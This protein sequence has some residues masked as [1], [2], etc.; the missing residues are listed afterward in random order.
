MTGC[1]GWLSTY[2]Y[3]HYLCT[4]DKQFLRNRVVPLLKNI[5]LFYTDFLEGMEDESGH[6]LFYPSVSPENR[7]SKMPDYRINDDGALAE[8]S[9]PGIED[10][11][12]H[13]HGSHLFDV[14]PGLAIDP[15]AM[16]RLYEAAQR[17]LELKVKAGMGN[18][19]AHGLMH[20]ALF[21]ARFKDPDMLW[22]LLDFF[23]RNRYLNRSLISSH[24]PDLRIYNLDAT[25]SLPAI[26][27]EMLAYSK[28]GVLD[29][30]PALPAVQLAK[31]S[32]EGMLARGVITIERLA[33]WNMP[34]GEIEL[35]VRSRENQ[36]IALGAPCPIAKIAVLQGKVRVEL[37]RRGPAWRDVALLGGE[38][39]KLL[40]ELTS[41]AQ[42]G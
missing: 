18:K 5:A 14:Y 4:G 41:E 6:Y 25:L 39:V 13:R 2:F 36:T 22:F 32:I 33:W 9:Y 12:D 11:Y 42:E 19:S 16:P 29:L 27:M 21:A 7:P 26:L 37:S 20:N 23:A 34:A 24:N 8:W 1:A 38:S 30:L 28:P 17:A 40:L 3:E 35:Q 31:G 10:N 15:Y